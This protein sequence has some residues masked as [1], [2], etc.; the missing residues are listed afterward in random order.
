MGL[1]AVLMMSALSSAMIALPGCADDEPAKPKAATGVS[2]DQL[3]VGSRGELP[4]CDATTEATLAYLLDEQK[5]VV[6]VSGEWKEV[7][8]PKGESGAQGNKGDKGETGAKGDKGD[9]GETGAEG[10]QGETGPKGERGEIGLQGIPGLKGDQGI[11]GVAGPE[12]AKGEIGPEGLPGAKG[13]QGAPGAKGDQGE[14]GEK[15][16]KGAQGAKGGQ[17]SAGENGKDGYTTLVK[18]VTLLPGDVECPAG[19][20]R[21]DVGVDL[22]RNGEL[23]G[24]EVVQSAPV[25]KDGPPGPS[26]PLKRVMFVTST[27]YDGNLGGISGADAKCQARAAAVGG[28]TFAGKTFKAWLSTYDT[29]P[30]ERFAKD[31]SFVTVKGDEIASSW[32][33]LT[34]GSLATPILDEYGH[35]ASAYVRTATM[36]NG[37]LE[38]ETGTCGAWSES[39]HG[40]SSGGHSS[41]M[42]MEWTFAVM[43]GCYQ[44][45]SLYCV[46]QPADG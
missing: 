39:G 18:L 6:C 31:G 36:P 24:A 7:A 1:R 22:N 41:M 46:E 21:I 34:D 27:P 13:E 40:Y 37:W 44:Q 14:K 32:D 17:G 23:D 19:G 20:V 15:G 28:P 35:A 8:F 11:P 43:L 30:A 45:A 42:D 10:D 25:C 2:L 9:Q 5:I 12:G 26:G 33:D 16:E 4:T 29:S 38:N 3:Q